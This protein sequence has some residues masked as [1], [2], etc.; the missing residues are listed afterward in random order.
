[1]NK[2]AYIINEVKGE[3]Y[4]I[5]IISKKSENYYAVK[6]NKESGEIIRIKHCKEPSEI[7]EKRVIKWQNI[8]LEIREMNYNDIFHADKRRHMNY[9]HGGNN[10][11]AKTKEFEKW[12]NDQNYIPTHIA[13]KV[14]KTIGKFEEFEV[15]Y[16]N[17]KAGEYY[18]N[19]KY[20]LTVNR[21]LNTYSIKTQSSKIDNAGIM[22]RAKESNIP[23]KMA[24]ITR[25]IAEDDSAINILERLKD[26]KTNSKLMVMFE[27]YDAN[28]KLNNKDLTRNEY[29]KI[30]KELEKIFGSKK[31]QKMNLSRKN[32]IALTQFLL[33]NS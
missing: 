32:F 19:Q 23:I 14:Y 21:G 28:R 8:P 10:K 15:V 18:I 30:K 5:E 22:N 9:V 2:K 6:M 4:V 26:L 31:I 25:F 7:I 13:W 29:N 17:S 1:M 16:Y 27:S 3:S 20:Y 33:E 11:S 24:E 12:L